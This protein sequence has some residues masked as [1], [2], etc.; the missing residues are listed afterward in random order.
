MRLLLAILAALL[1]GTCSRS[2]SVLEQ[3]IQ[4]GELRVVTRNS[5]STYYLGANGPQGPEFEM[6][7]RLAA[8]LGVGLYMYSMP[9]LGDVLREV[10]EGRAHVAAAGLTLGQPLPKH[11][12]FGPRYQQVKEHLVFRQDESRPRTLREAA[13]GHIEVASESSHAATLEQ[14]RVQHPDLVWVENPGT[15]TEE[16]LNRLSARDIDYTIA[17]SNEFAVSRAYHPEM[18][19]AFDLTQ[20]KSLAWAMN[21][22]DSS[23]PTRIAAFF[24]A[25]AAEGQLTAILD[26]HYSNLRRFEYVQARD[27]VDHVSTRLPLYRDGFKEAAEQ[28]GVDWRLLSAMGYQESQWIPDATSPTGVRGLMM[29]TEDTA[30]SLDVT[31]RLDPIQSIFGG[32]RY[33]VMVRNKVPPRIRDP[34][35]TWF[36]LAAYNVGFGHLEDAR[37]LTQLHKKDPDRWDDVRQYLPLLSQEKWYARVKHGYAR[38]WEPVRFVDNIRTYYEMLQW[39]TTEQDVDAQF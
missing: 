36:A 34:D 37:I 30:R 22:R 18:R 21:A 6:A 29:L 14:L 4:A 39:M 20:G 26:R 7:S 1:L 27:F 23:L 9:T 31:D 2:A 10:A 16:L 5:P 11:L 24:T 38:G 13:A 25:L 19:V 8:D 32:A 35:R 28:V 3:I 12:S 17:D 33:F 15:E